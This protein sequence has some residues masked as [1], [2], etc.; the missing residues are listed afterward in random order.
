MCRINVAKAK[1]QAK[2]KALFSAVLA[3]VEAG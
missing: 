3:Q 2:A 1:A